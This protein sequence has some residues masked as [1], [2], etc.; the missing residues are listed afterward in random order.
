MHESPSYDP[1]AAGAARLVHAWSLPNI[2]TYGRILAVPALVVFFYLENTTGRWLSFAVFVAASVTDFFDGYLA[3]AWHQ[4]S[5]IG[6]ILD[7][8]A[9][10]LLVAV[11]LV[12]LVWSGTI[13]SW[14]L[15]AALVILTREISVSGL[16]EFLAGLRVSVPVSRLAK[17]KTT[18]Q[19]VAI[20]FLLIG[21]AGD[22]LLR[23]Y[24]GDLGLVTYVGLLLLWVSA[25]ITLYTGYDYFRAGLRHVAGEDK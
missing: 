6:Q 4:Q 21:P 19:M 2:L 23:Y 12:L 11:A 17:W 9:D 14:S 10:K 13:G 8:I 16:R 24:F 1:T 25:L 22:R 15:L 7:P 18:L 20:A 5:A 3:R